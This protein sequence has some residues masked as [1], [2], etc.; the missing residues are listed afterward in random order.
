V[1]LRRRLARA[2]IL[3]P[4]LAIF[5]GDV[6]RRPTQVAHFG[7]RGFVFYGL[8]VVV[9]FVLWGS[10]VT[11]AARRGGSRTMRIVAWTLLVAAALFALGAQGYTF[12][13]YMAYI[14][15][16]AVLVGTSMMPSI[17]QQ[18]WSDRFTVAQSV[19]PP[20]LVALV[21]PFV[22]RGL[23]SARRRSTKIALDLGVVAL[24]LALFVS[25][26]RG[27]EQGQPPD[28]M[29]ISAM[30][31]L[32]RAKWD[33]NETVDRIHPGHRT[34]VEV[35]PLTAKPP[36]RRNV[37]FVLTESVR[38]MSVCLDYDDKNC[39]YTPFSNAAA[40]KRIALRQMRAVDS[41]TAISLSVMWT[42][43]APDESRGTLHTVP[44]LWEYLHSARLD[45]GYW[46]SQN[47]LFGNAGA[48]L[49]GIP[50]TRRVSA[51]QLEPEP[52]LDVGADDGKLVDYVSNDLAS[53]REPYFGVVHLSNTHFPYKVDH[54]YAPFLPEEE[55]TG[56]GYETELRNR[57][58]DAVY[59]QDRATGRLLEAVRGRPEGDRTIIVYLSDHG[60]Q[61]REKGAAGHTGTLYEEEIRIPFWIDAPPGTL[62]ADEEQKLRA[63]VDTPVTIYDVLPTMLDL[64]G[65]LD[66]PRIASFRSHMPGQSLLR[67][68]TPADHPVF[69]TNCTELWAC[70]FKNWGAMRGSQKLI[71]NQGDHTWNCF[72][73]EHDPQE[74]H[75]LP[76][77]ACGDLVSVAETRGR[78]RP[79][80]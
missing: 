76:P 61:L 54:A 28:V 29:Y 15:H 18:L 69:M 47:M 67:G 38:S 58:Q 37:L 5:L 52:G 75:P 34:P 21:L 48:W 57:Y 11:V 60:E 68:G 55:A 14:D 32:A 44:L 33:H 80:R 42:G 41:T 10:L 73:L 36:V 9:S 72:D 7:L 31:Q 56:P 71:A 17:G 4:T 20:V 39:L 27:A 24:L 78:G 35:P 12:A 43:Y 22:V 26:S 66:E 19:V 23:A 45:S 50:A 3:L 63:L 49:E 62:T 46:T 51:T 6:I 59:L 64:M 13:R 65:L 70:A 30:G 74:L 77:E 8:C 53:L 25:P 16:Q 79:F 40:P 1:K 2:L